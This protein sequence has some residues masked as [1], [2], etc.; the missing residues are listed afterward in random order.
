MEKSLFIG[1]E[2]LVQEPVNY[3]VDIQGDEV[4]NNSLPLRMLYYSYAAVH[5]SFVEQRR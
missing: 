4:M 5:G 2:L 1:C 3:T